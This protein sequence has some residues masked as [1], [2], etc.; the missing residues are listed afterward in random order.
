MSY[1]TDH[2]SALADVTDAGARVTFV[3]TVTVAFN[4]TVDPVP[5][6]A[7]QTV[8]GSAVRV[9]GNPLVYAAL[10]LSLSEAP[11]LFVT[12]DVYGLI[13]LPGDAVTWGGVAFVV[14]DVNPIAP[15]G[16]AIAARVVVSR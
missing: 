12:P 9:K 3:R 5:V 1:S 4:P 16:V 10:S 13:P 2:A 11:T 6:Q 15:D 14:R 8:T 7:T